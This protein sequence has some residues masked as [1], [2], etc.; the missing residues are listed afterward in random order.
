[1]F[2]FGKCCF[3]STASCVCPWKCSGT[4]FDAINQYMSADSVLSLVLT[5]EQ[6]NLLCAIL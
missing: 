3:D 1:M 5:K 2:A 4:V 6:D